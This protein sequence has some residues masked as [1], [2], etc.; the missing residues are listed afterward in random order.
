MVAVAEYFSGAL[1]DAIFMADLDTMENE[2]V[3]LADRLFGNPKSNSHLNREQS[4]KEAKRRLYCPSSKV[5]SDVP[6]TIPS[7]SPLEKRV[8]RVVNA[9]ANVKDAKTCE[10][11]FSKETWKVHKNFIEKIRSEIISDLPG[12]DYYYTTTNSSGQTTLWCVRGTLQL[13]GFHRHLRSIFPGFHTSSRLSILPLAL[14]I[15]R[16][17]IDQAVERG[18]LPDDYS[19]FYQHQLIMEIHELHSKS[20]REGPSRFPE[21]PNIQDVKDT[22]ERFITPLMR[23]LAGVD[24]DTDT[25]GDLSPGMEFSARRDNSL[26]PYTPVLGCET[27]LIMDLIREFSENRGNSRSINQHSLCDYESAA[28]TWTERCEEELEKPTV[29]RCFQ[30]LLCRFEVFMLSINAN[31]MLLQ[32]HVSGFRSTVAVVCMKL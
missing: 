29:E 12:F 21:F 18:L 3:K 30:K 5:L 31:K 22:L 27:A 26:L 10:V 9:C 16:W 19:N 28:A 6:R 17:N 15:F 23:H 11:F 8:Q 1:R 32:Q 7:P 20:K 4:E 13:E 14:F 2:R 25:D 24:A